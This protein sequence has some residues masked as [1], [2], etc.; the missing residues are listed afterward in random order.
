MGV[1]VTSTCGGRPGGGILR[2]GPVNT[3][4]VWSE[5]DR[6]IVG[7]RVA[8]ACKPSSRGLSGE[9]PAGASGPVSLSVGSCTTPAA[10]S[11]C[12]FDIP[13]APRRR[14]GGNPYRVRGPGGNGTGSDT[15]PT[16][17]VQR[18]S[19]HQRLDILSLRAYALAIYAIAAAAF[20]Q[21]G[22]RPGLHDV[23]IQV[24]DELPGAST[25]RQRRETSAAAQGSRPGRLKR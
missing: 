16:P 1:A 12:P 5:R 22:E 3:T 10:A 21:L 2:T 7:W 23:Q 18:A 4:T 13:L 9:V 25:R 24:M 17:S 6:R 8:D 20:L 15:G 19:Q 11:A 14:R